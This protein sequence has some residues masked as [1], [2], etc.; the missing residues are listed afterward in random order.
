QTRAPRKLGTPRPSTGRRDLRAPT[1]AK[2]PLA[3]AAPRLWAVWAGAASPDAA[4]RASVGRRGS[5]SA[6]EQLGQPH[7]GPRAHR[8]AVQVGH[9]RGTV[10]G[11]LFE[12]S[13]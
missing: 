9:T 7:G 2:Q 4:S 10:H 5:P 8:A 13:E 3:A 6:C 12:S 11:R 1:V